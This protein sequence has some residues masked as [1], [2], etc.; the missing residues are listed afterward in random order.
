V[1]SLQNIVVQSQDGQRQKDN[2]PTIDFEE[3]LLALNQEFKTDLVN[4]IKAALAES[5]GAVPL[6]LPLTETL[7]CDI[8]DRSVE[9]AYE[10]QKKIGDVKR[11]ISR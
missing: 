2:L 4:T 5:R 8:F 10:T 1:Q 9:Q 11:Q 3:R 6:Q 7:S